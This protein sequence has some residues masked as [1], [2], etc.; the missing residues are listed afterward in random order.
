MNVEI[1]F[2]HRHSNIEFLTPITYL[3]ISR[4]HIIDVSRFEGSI[5]RLCL[6]MSHTVCG[7]QYAEIKP[8]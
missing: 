4:V 6:R 1:Q 3:A 5:I 2:E 7:I 8:L